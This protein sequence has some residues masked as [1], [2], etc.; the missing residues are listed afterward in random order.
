MPQR[1][2]LQAANSTETIGS[3][4]GTRASSEVGGWGPERS[5]A[6]QAESEMG[7]IVSA[8]DMYPEDS[9]LI[10]ELVVRSHPILLLSRC[11]SHTQPGGGRVGCQRIWG[12]VGRGAGAD[13][14]GRGGGAGAAGNLGEE[15]GGVQQQLCTDR[16]VATANPAGIAASIGL[17]G[18]DRSCCCKDIL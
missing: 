13:T 7:S 10:E 8:P 3:K 4:D 6:S 12:G 5:R 16:Q 1:L 14:P 15:G 11:C 17:S 9:G 2:R 18:G